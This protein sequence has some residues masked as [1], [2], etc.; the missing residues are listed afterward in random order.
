MKKVLILSLLLTFCIS[1]CQTISQE[2]PTQV[3]ETIVPT[4]TAQ[5]S[6]TPTST[7]TPTPTI[8]VTPTPSVAYKLTGLNFGPYTEAGQSPDL[9]T[10]IPAEQLEM[11]LRLL[12]PYTE[13][14]RTYG[15]AGFEEI[16]P[17][18]HQLG[19][20]VALGAWLGKDEAAND[21]EISCLVKTD[22][23][24]QPEML[25]VG[26]ETLHR[27]DLS[28]AQLID[29][30]QTVKSV[31]PDLTVAT[32]ETDQIWLKNSELVDAS[33][34]I[35]ANIY[36]YWGG[37]DADHAVY[38]L[39]STYSKLQAL[40]GDKEVWVSET[41]WADSGDTL[42]AAVPSSE[43]A[44]QYLLNFVSW[45]RAKNV[46]YFY[47]EAFDEPWK[48]TEEN[49]Q[50]AHWGIWT[51]SYEMKEGMGQV[52]EGNEVPDNWTATVTPVPTKA[53]TV[54]AT[55]KPTEVVVQGPPSISISLPAGKNWPNG[56]V[57]WGY[58][59]NVDPTKYRVAVYIKVNGGWWTKP[60]FDSPLTWISANGYWECSYITG[61]EDA[62]AS[63]IA[64]F[65]VPANA[66]VP[67]ANGGGLPE[68]GSYPVAKISR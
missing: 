37:V 54:S 56:G 51:S 40:A 65:L 64:A 67:Q 13:W 26:S 43:N 58:T 57:V 21:E 5:N 12:A 30:M 16:V 19:L 17:V 68:M 1:S 3:S 29:Y 34:V 2:P 39:N 15:C 22:V 45:A 4:S 49:P 10:V 9:G 50:E 31:L 18:A 14:I 47:F 55:R 35:L 44:A 33:D 23:L 60:F 52:F 61:G 36:P 63:E 6:P 28:V 11:Q 7:D 46:N 41:G 42:Q 27:G 32:A 8:T 48:G 62:S 38:S 25:I 53:P 59:K 24:Y 20:K 66:S